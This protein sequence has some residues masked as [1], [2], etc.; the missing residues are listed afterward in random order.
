LKK[1]QECNNGGNGFGGI[2]E[3]KGS[4]QGVGCVALRKEEKG[5][6]KID[7]GRD[8]IGQGMPELPMTKFMSENGKN[9]IVV[10][11]FQQCIKENCTY[12]FGEYIK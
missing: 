5:S 3:P 2:I 10:Y 8:E 11:L 1:E 9:F 6:T 4:I 12:K 7:L